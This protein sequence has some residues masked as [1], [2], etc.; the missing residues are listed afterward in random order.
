MSTTY[1]KV[2][3]RMILERAWE[4]KPQAFTLMGKTFTDHRL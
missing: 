3:A 1:Q 2:V 4:K